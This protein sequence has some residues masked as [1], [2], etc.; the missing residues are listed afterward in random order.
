MALDRFNLA[1]NDFEKC[2]SNSF[3]ELLD[4]GY[5]VDVTLASDD[6]YHIKAH[7]VVL[8][9]CSPVLKSILEKHPHQHP[10]IYMSGIKYQELKAIIN[11]MYVGETEVAHDKLEIFM[12]I[13]AKFK[14]KG[15]SNCQINEEPS[16]PNQEQAKLEF[17]SIHKDDP[18]KEALEADKKDE[19][20]DAQG[21]TPKEEEDNVVNASD[22]KIMDTYIESNQ[23]KKTEESKEPT[24]IGQEYFCQ[25]CDYKARFRN[26]VYNHTAAQHE[27]KRFP[28]D[29]CQYESKY[30][31]DLIKHKGRK[32][33]Y[34]KYTSKR[35]LK[36]KMIDTNV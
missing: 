5:F 8:S 36:Q 11:F 6:D 31:G 2:V 13:A 33:L 23:L 21:L 1:W 15:L 29:F 17:K 14:I 35:A 27:G 16:R 32:H 19:N 7:K 25:Y 26:N 4:N 34:N 9:T 12:S 22:D 20:N 10:L 30:Y 28:C 3:K 18:L 24:K